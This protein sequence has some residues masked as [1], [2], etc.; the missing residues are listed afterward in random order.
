[1][2]DPIES[3]QPSN[4]ITDSAIS[5]VRLR[6]GAVLA[7]AVEIAERLA[8][9]RTNARVPIPLPRPARFACR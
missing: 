9:G 3:S 2:L 4:P 7:A 5:P 6:L 8:G 1:M